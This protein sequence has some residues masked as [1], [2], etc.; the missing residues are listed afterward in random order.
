MNKVVKIILSI[1]SSII[2]FIVMIPILLG[3]MLQIG[4][5]QNFAVDR[6]TEFLSQKAGVTISVGRVGIDFFSRA[7]LSDVYMSDMA[8][9]TMIYVQRLTANVSSINF[10]SGKVNMSGVTLENGKCYLFRDS[11]GV[12]NVQRAFAGFQSK[13]SKPSTGNL[14]LNARELN[15]INFHFKLKYHDAPG[16]LFGVNYKDMDVTNIYMQA[17]DIRVENYDVRFLMSNLT[18]RERSGFYLQHME[19]EDVW[20]N[21]TGLRFAGLTLRTLD[22]D[23]RAPRLDMLYDSWWAYTDFVNDVR[24]DAQID[25]SR[26]SYRT[27]SYFIGRSAD[28][29]T[30]VNFRGEMRG[31]VAKMAGSLRQVHTYDTDLSCDFTISGLPDIQRSVFSVNLLSLTTNGVD[32]QRI[33]SEVAGRELSSGVVKILRRGGDLSVS[34][35][36]AGLLNDFEADAVVSVRQG[37]VR[38]DL[39]FS[40]PDTLSSGV[41]NL[42]GRMSMKDF[43]AGSLLAVRDMGML[44]VDGAV[45]AT[46]GL[47]G[48]VRLSTDAAISRLGWGGYDY[49]GVDMRG[50]FS[51]SRFTGTVV[52]DDP[53]LKFRTNGEFD[54]TSAMPSYNFEMALVRAN[55]AALGFN[56]RDSVSVLSAR[57]K[58]HAS[59]STLDNVNGTAVFDSILYINHVDTVRTGSIYIKSVN[60]EQAKFLSLESDFADLEL[61]GSNSYRNMW[62]YFIKSVNRYVPSMPYESVGDVLGKSG[63]DVVG[64][65]SDAAEAD[66]PYDDGYYMLRVDV[67]R[68][69]NVAGIFVPGLNVASG[70]QFTFYFN[71]F[72]DQFNV[73]CRSG[74][75][76]RGDF[77][78]EDFYFNSRNQQDSVAIYMSAGY[79]GYGVVDLPNFSVMGGVSNNVVTLGLKFRDTTVNSGGFLQTITTFRR[80]ALGMPQAELHILPSVVA[81]KGALWEIGDCRFTADSTGI[82]VDGFSLLGSGQHLTIAGRAGR[83]LSD[84]LS[85]GLSNFSI[86]PFTAFVA[87]L[88][89]DLSGRV[90]GEAHGVGLLGRGAQVVADLKF[91]DV[92]LSGHA[93][94]SAVL[95][96]EFDRESRNVR[97]EVMTDSGQKPIYG[98]YDVGRKRYNINFDFPT[99][100]MV[101]LEPM[102]KG[103][104]VNTVGTAE[105]KVNLSGSG[106]LARLNGQVDIKSYSAQVEFTGVRYNFAGPV[107]VVNNRFE[108][109]A[110]PISD[111]GNGHGNISGYFDSDYF[112]NLRYGVSA[113]FQNLLC[114][115][116]T[117]ADSELFYGRAYASGFF[118]LTGHDTDV[119]MNIVA[120]TAENS[121][122][123]LPLSNV[124]SISEADFINFVQP[125]DSADVGRVGVSRRKLRAQA[126]QRVRAASELDIQMDL[127]VLP[128]TQA[129]IVID[130]QTGSSVEG[131][132]TG[133]LMMNINPSKGIFT[134]N[135]PFDVERGSYRFVLPELA[136]DKRFAIESNGSMMWSGDPANPYINVDAVYKLKA[137]IATLT[138]TVGGANAMVAVDCGINLT[139]N[140]LNPNIRLSITAPLADAETQNALSNSLNTE[141]S[142]MTQF[143]SL[144]LNRSFMPDFNSANIG[145]MTGSLVGVTI[146]EFLSNQI[147]NLV[148]SDKFNFRIGYRPSDNTTYG[149]EVNFEV[150][151]ELIQNVLSVEVGG[152]YNTGNNPTSTG[153]NPFSGDANLT[154]TMNKAG[155]LKLKGFTRV[156]DRFDETQGLQESGVGVYF[157]QD[158]QNVPDLKRRYAKWRSEARSNREVRQQKRADRV[159]RSG[160]ADRADRAG[161]AGHSRDSSAVVDVAVVEK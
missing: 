123:V 102:L 41:V 131:R 31:P 56:K 30:V 19:A 103:I 6:L 38:G 130:P 139:G 146:S 118:G 64:E 53:N 79:M 135:G 46:L 133:H 94:G 155:T 83:M 3:I 32:V 88:G 45:N 54:L 4:P 126:K 116:T 1:I 67:K 34:G 51:G 69:N 18:L 11:A 112:K 2:I 141:E 91:D 121:S 81:V 113:N 97:L 106:A 68:A 87:G 14:L 86:A 93:L 110:T 39:R 65:V 105:A 115:N 136:I 40:S 159:A 150:G 9:D 84:T 98:V 48:G 114:L 12:M 25:L 158:F 152:N 90:G 80:T 58:A 143:L 57:F 100:N 78:V 124:A 74:Y 108:L 59:G 129:Q 154:W 70:T 132:G 145:T 128:N 85:V 66:K 52:C 63:G 96:S 104:L 37:S 7:S 109:A 13:N 151:S 120:Q 125:V 49:Q 5:L 137:S 157:R 77:L 27:L 29:N 17:R 101:L 26:L 55:L 36:F 107:K 119:K 71:P 8:G 42:A 149:D 43:D 73:N 21:G 92:A 76:E 147:S 144:L 28:V 50:Q 82:A 153:R 44:S 10:L 127:N 20:V 134:L 47:S 72:L 160:R 161:R 140:M 33:Y 156:I 122:F 142:T 75:I 95:R 60:D 111:G 22:S 35:S 24:F 61:K 16:R 117:V 138:G 15:L 62:R 99:L 89:Y 23:I 148:S